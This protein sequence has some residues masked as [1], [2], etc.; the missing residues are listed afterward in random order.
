[1]G[2]RDGFSSLDLQKLNKLY[3][4]SNSDEPETSGPASLTSTT[5]RRSV[6]TETKCENKKWQ[7]FFWYRLNYCSSYPDYMR[8]YCPKSCDMC[9]QPERERNDQRATTPSTTRGSTSSPSGTSD[10]CKDN[11]SHCGSWTRKGY[12]SKTGFSAYMRRT[13]PLSCGICTQAAPP[14]MASMADDDN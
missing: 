6:L 11:D 5:T 4:C 2:Q 9:G 12:C 13:C 1:M 8:Q 10:E 7:C 14:S 3:Q